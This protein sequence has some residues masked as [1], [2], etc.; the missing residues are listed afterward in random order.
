MFEQVARCLSIVLAV[1]L[2]PSEAVA[3]ASRPQPSAVQQEESSREKWQKVGEILEA[4]AVRPGSTV[5]D[6]GAGD[7]FFTVRLA[8]AVGQTG[9][10]VAVDVSPRAVERLRLRLDQEGLTNVETVQGDAD[11]PRL[12]SASLDAAVIVNSYHEMHEYK[13]MLQHLKSA[14]KPDARL[15][16]VEPISEKRREESRDQQVSVHEIAVRFVEQEAREAGFRIRRLEDPFTTRP[17][18]IEW[19]LVAVPDQ[20]APAQDAICALPPKRSAA[21]P[22]AA[23]E[24]EAAIAAPDL[25]IAFDIFKKRLAED[26]I[27]VVDVRSEDE[28]VAGH[29]PGAIWIPASRV[30]SQVAELEARRKPIITYCS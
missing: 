7:G 26:T 9:Q 11:N 2:A 1:A 21:P 18:S 4:M 24:D 30:V 20:L 15:V 6:V 29:V 19:L 27:V 22:S 12:P 8:R 25:R 28:F 14:L 16:I 13:A 3:Q 23:T 10:V 5:A 17:N